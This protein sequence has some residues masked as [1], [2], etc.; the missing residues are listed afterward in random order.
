MT[1]TSR[2][3]TP[4]QTQWSERITAWEVSGLSQSSFC[5]QHDLVYGTFVYWRS[6]LKKLKADMEQPESISFF[7]VTLKSE[8]TASLVLRVND[9]H[10]I[11]LKSD[12]DPDLLGKVIQV[13][14]QIV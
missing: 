13:I 7:P 5:K 10:S 4:T 12:F 8:K 14:Q 1:T 3:L 6:H 11:E 9:Q 2:S